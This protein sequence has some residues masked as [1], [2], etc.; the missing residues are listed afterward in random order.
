LTCCPLGYATGPLSRSVLGRV[1]WRPA[2]SGRGRRPG[3]DPGCTA[4]V[5]P[6]GRWAT[7]DVACADGRYLLSVTHLDVIGRTPGAV[8]T[9]A[10]A[11]LAA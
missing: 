9:L 11:A 4:R 3:A 5:S 10:V 7:P 8:V 2:P 1:G 6:S